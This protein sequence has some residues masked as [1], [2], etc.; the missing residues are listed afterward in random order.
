MCT[1]NCYHLAS[2]SATSGS[3][4]DAGLPNIEADIAT[5]QPTFTAWA[6]AKPTGA[7]KKTIFKSGYG[8]T[9]IMS[10]RADLYFDASDSNPIYGNSNTVQ[11]NSFTVRYIIKY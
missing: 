1:L 5:G 11:P 9:N 3:Y 6:K 4:H 10:Y 8:Q 7:F 2:H